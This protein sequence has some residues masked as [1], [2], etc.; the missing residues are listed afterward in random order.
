MRYI[1]R[2]EPESIDNFI[3]CACSADDICTHATCML[4]T[5]TIEMKPILVPLFYCPLL[6][7][8][9]V[10]WHGRGWDPI[11]FLFPGADVGLDF[12]T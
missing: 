5:S 9:F 8:V 4:Y 2:F 7:L 1:L 6:K 11:F 12:Q 3:M 10:L